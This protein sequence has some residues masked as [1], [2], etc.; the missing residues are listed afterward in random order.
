[1]LTHI[2]GIALTMLTMAAI[3]AAVIQTILFLGA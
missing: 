3:Y 2:K 1:M